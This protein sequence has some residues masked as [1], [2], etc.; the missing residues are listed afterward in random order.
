MKS[1][2]VKMIESFSSI[3]SSLFSVIF[4]GFLHSSLMHFFGRCVAKI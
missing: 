1:D 2:I 3:R 4:S